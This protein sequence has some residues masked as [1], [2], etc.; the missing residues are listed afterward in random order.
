MRCWWYYIGGREPKNKHHKSLYTVC[1]QSPC[2]TQFYFITAHD[3]AGKC[4]G[5][6]AFG[7][8][9]SLQRATQEDL[10]KTR[11]LGVYNPYM[12]CICI[13]RFISTLVCDDGLFWALLRA[14]LLDLI[15]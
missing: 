8:S 1:A 14:A 4:N 5:N 11:R 12:V 3:I 6:H 2:G 13:I 9:F 7:F 15:G 10:Y